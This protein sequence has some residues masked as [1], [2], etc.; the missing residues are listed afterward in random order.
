[1]SQYLRQ[2]LLVMR[3]KCFNCRS[4]FT[5]SFPSQHVHVFC[6]NKLLD[7][8][9][10]ELPKSNNFLQCTNVDFVEIRCLVQWK[11][12]LNLMKKQRQ[13]LWSVITSLCRFHFSFHLLGLNN[14]LFG[15]THLEKN[16]IIGA[17]VCMRVCVCRFRNRRRKRSENMYLQ[18]FLYDE[19][20][21][22]FEV[23]D[24]FWQ[25]HG[26]VKGE[27]TRWEKRSDGNMYL[28]SKPPN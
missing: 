19:F 25:R 21:F 5:E 8:I 11:C 20:S 3:V 4:V 7:S 23:A 13:R 10:E 2:P 16:T 27:K 14:Q 28:F 1:M 12:S 26:T 22:I 17:A 6:L 15:F 9:H 24:I 18:A